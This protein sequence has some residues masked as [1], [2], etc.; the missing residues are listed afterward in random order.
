MSELDN[1]RQWLKPMTYPNPT[2]LYHISTYRDELNELLTVKRQMFP[3]PCVV[4]VY[5]NSYQGHGIVW[6]NHDEQA[7]DRLS[8]FVS[9][10]NTWDYP[11]E[12][13][14]RDDDRAKWPKWIKDEFEDR[15]L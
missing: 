13:C 9:S 5:S 15:G 14:R 10:G 12:D 7:A 1:D 3:V 2:L 4:W 11:L 6:S 8:V